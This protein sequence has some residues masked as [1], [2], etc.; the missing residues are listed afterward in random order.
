MSKRR[1]DA[2]D[3]FAACPLC[4]DSDRI[5]DA[6]QSV[7]WCRKG[8]YAVQQIAEQRLVRQVTVHNEHR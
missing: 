7:A 1:I 8:T 4:P 2:P 3:E 6:R 5:G